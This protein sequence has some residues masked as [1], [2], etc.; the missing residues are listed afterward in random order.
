MHPIL[1]STFPDL[2]QLPG[3]T[4]A[5]IY[6]DLEG[7]ERP[8]LS[9][10][11]DSVVII[12]N[13]VS[14]TDVSNLQKIFNNSPNKE[15]VS[16][17]GRKNE[18]IDNYAGSERLSIWAPNL[19]D[20]LYKLLQPF[21]KE[22]EFNEFSRT[23][24]W[25]EPFSY[26]WRPIGLSPLLRMMSYPPGALHLPHYD[27]AFIYPDARYRSLM[28]VLFYLSSHQNGGSTRILKDGQE[29]IPESLRNHHDR[30]ATAGPEE[31]LFKVS[32]KSGSVFLFDH[33][34][35]HDAEPCLEERILIRTD[36]VFEAI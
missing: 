5:Q 17:L 10:D 27:A 14:E 20:Q 33:R 32:P 22:R 4:E 28:S 2:K 6:F 36:L 7:T 19:S 25:Q 26:K 13:L 11:Q 18:K 12:E 8:L 31:V 3:G 24:F 23:D 15:T 21:L 9:E 35:Y 16:A 34:L 30:D 29:M 1:S